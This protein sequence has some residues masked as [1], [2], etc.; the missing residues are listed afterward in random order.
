[1]IAFHVVDRKEDLNNSGTSAYVLAFQGEGN[2]R[3]VAYY[4][5]HIRRGL[6]WGSNVNDG[7]RPL[8]YG[9]DVKLDR[10]K[11]NRFRLEVRGNHIEVWIDGR[12][13]VDVIDEE[14][15]EPIDGRTLDHGGVAFVGAYDAMIR[16]RNFEMT[17]L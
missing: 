2:W 12:K 3:L 7:E 14:M 5:D 1:M 16:L 10:V 13:I 8:A 17:K 9:E 6:G 4:D 11:G 15:D